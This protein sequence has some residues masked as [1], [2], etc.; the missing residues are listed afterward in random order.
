MP[1]PTCWWA[2]TAG[3]VLVVPH[4]LREARWWTRLEP[5]FEHLSD[6]HLKERLAEFAGLFRPSPC[7]RSRAVR[8]ALACSR[9]ARPAASNRNAWV[10]QIAGALAAPRLPRRTATG[11]GKTLSAGLAATLAAWSGH[12]VHIITANDYLARRDARWMGPLYRFCG[13]DAGA[14]GGDL[15]QEDRRAAY[16]RPV[17]YATGKEVVADFLRDRLRLGRHQ[18]FG[19]RVVPGIVRGDLVAPAQPVMRGIHT[20]IVDE[21]DHILVDE[22]VTPVI[23]SSPHPNEMFTQACRQARDLAARLEA[24]RDFKIDTGYR[25]IDLLPAGRARIEAM[26]SGMPGL[27]KAPRRST[28][29]ILQALLAEHLYENGKQY[30]VQGEKIVIVDEFTGRLMHQRTW[31]EGLH[32]AVEVKEGLPLSDLSETSMRLS[33]QRFFRFYQRL[34]GMTGTAKEA[35][36]ELW[37]IYR[38]PVVCIP[39]HRPVIRKNLEP[40]I[41]ADEESKWRAIVQS[42]VEVHA[43]KRPVLVGVRSVRQSEKLSELLMGEGLHHR[44]LNAVRHEEEANV[45][46]EAGGEGRITIATN[47]AG[48]GTD[49]LLGHGIAESGGLHVLATEFHEAGRVDRQLY[50]R[51][52]RQGDPGSAITFGSLEDELAV[53]YVP[54]WIRRQ[55]ARWIASGVRGHAAFARLLVRSAQ[56]AAEFRAFGQRR[57]VLKTDTWLE[58]SLAFGRAAIRD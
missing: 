36:G 30:V 45:I 23:L 38:L 54:G 12:P 6:H 35:A 31:R 48:R 8:G 33:F 15:E 26:S 43:T 1:S 24:G 28:E 51:S 58:E 39:P 9:E 2:A 46:A 57:D 55:A 56:R 4:L 41:F 11:E 44:V 50:G 10:V 14:V 19:V 25:I 20:A 13:L 40:R 34:S 27:W 47:M 49:I 42:I 32:Q 21:A 52:G 37:R 53:R 16:A 5:E 29:L 3:V 18:H 17:T 22:S 7:P